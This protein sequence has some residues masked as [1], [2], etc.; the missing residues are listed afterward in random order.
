MTLWLLGIL[1]AVAVSL[2][3]AVTIWAAYIWGQ[4]EIVSARW[5]DSDEAIHMA[6]FRELDRRTDGVE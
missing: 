2:M 3:W 6:A 1:L 4:S 5:D